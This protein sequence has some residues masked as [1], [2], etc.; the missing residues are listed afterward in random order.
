MYNNKITKNSYTSNS[1][2]LVFFVSILALSLFMFYMPTSYSQTE[3]DEFLQEQSQQPQQQICAEG[4]VFN[5]V[6]QVCESIA[7]SS[8]DL[9]TL[10]QDVPVEEIPAEEIPAEEIPAEE[11]APSEEI[12][13]PPEEKLVPTEELE[14]PAEELVA[15][16]EEEL[17]ALEGQQQGTITIP[18]V[19]IRNYESEN[20]PC[21]PNSETLFWD[22]KIP[23]KY[24]EKVI[25]LQTYLKD[26]GFH[27]L[28]EPEG[29]DGKFGPHT[30]KAVIEFQKY[31]GLAG[32]ILTPDGIVGPKTWEALCSEINKLIAQG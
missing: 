13:P 21:D 1:I 31:M 22:G 25:A 7:T 11:L 4:E 18:E 23:V 29:V 20:Y 8:T 30:K 9:E 19:I 14:K 5:E 27:Q 32:V 6:T 12:P 26:L 3:S 17:Q 15:K 28:L 2:F 16:S 10:T 24:N